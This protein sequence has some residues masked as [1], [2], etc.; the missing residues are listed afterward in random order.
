MCFLHSKPGCDLIQNYTG[1]QRFQVWTLLQSHKTI[2]Y[3]SATVPTYKITTLFTIHK[4][5]DNNGCNYRKLIYIS[6]KYF[7]VLLKK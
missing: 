7:W 6:E 2:V 4:K 1:C 5:N 3:T